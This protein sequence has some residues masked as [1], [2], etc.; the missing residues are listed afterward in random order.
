MP[1]KMKAQK[2]MK[3]VNGE[4]AIQPRYKPY[5]LRN[6]STSQLYYFFKVQG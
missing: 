6:G 2:S 3:P 4:T 5:F 1:I